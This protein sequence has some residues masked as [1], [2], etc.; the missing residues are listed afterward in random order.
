MLH[1]S[2]RHKFDLRYIW[3]TKDQLVVPNV[4][5]RNLHQLKC[6]F[7]NIKKVCVMLTRHTVLCHKLCA[8]STIF[9]YYGQNSCLKLIDL[10]F[11]FEFLAINCTKWSQ[12]LTYTL[13]LKDECGTIHLIN[14]MN[15]KNSNNI[16]LHIK[17][18]PSLGNLNLSAFS[19]PY[20]GTCLP[21]KSTKFFL[22]PPRWEAFW[23][24]STFRCCHLEGHLGLFFF[25]EI[26]SAFS[27][28]KITTTSH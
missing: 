26:L 16:S 25:F 13:V 5:S 19:Y 15:V 17:K 3:D 28:K 11:S 20:L 21:R 8:M 27:F 4:F 9:I 10:F 1:F 12:K 6:C 14:D 23:G 7:F 2:V 22:P 18:G 24:Y